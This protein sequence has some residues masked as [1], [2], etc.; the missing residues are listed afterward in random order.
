MKHAISLVAPAKHGQFTKRRLNHLLE[1]IIGSHSSTRNRIAVAGMLAGSTL[2]SADLHAAILSFDTTSIAVDEPN[3]GSQ[4]VA[5]TLRATFTDN[6]SGW[7]NLTPCTIS[8]TIGIR[9]QGSEIPPATQDQDFT[10]ITTSFSMTTEPYTVGEGQVQIDDVSQEILFEVLDDGDEN[11]SLETI[12]F[13]ITSY[14][15]SCG[16][17]ISRSISLGTTKGAIAI[18]DPFDVKPPPNPETPPSRPSAIPV[19]QKNLTAQLNSLRNLTLHSSATRDRGIAK[20]IDRARKSR[21][22]SSTNLTVKAH[23]QS[24]PNFGAG[25]GDALDNFGRW[26]LFV[27]GSVDLGHQQKGTANSSEFDSSLLIVGAD[28]QVNDHLILGSALS[29]T[30]VNSGSAQTAKTDF[31]RASFSLFASVYVAEVYYLDAIATVGASNYDLQRKID[32]G[33][34]SQDSASATTDGGETT[35]S[36]GAGYNFH[37]R[38]LNLRIFSF[39]NYIDSNIDSYREVVLGSSS[40]ASVNGFDLQS[41]TADLGFELSWNINSA[42]GVFTPALSLAQEHQFADDAV[43]INGQ[44]IGGD[45]EGGFYFH[46][47]QQD[48]DYLSTQI[49]ISGVFRNGFAAYLTYNTHLRREDFSSSQ[50]SL[51]ARWQF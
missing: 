51:G 36:I 20:E 39:V 13:E 15:A 10:H 23:G 8:G 19:R 33:E 9:N 1:L 38:N 49:G 34:S 47:P 25:A 42:F 17:E 41:L 40:A 5:V 50:Y 2:L 45:D 16:A 37:Q 14:G 31:D 7:Q 11:E 26:G 44:F 6:A 27:S 4:T 12:D 35:V 48:D 30:I 28:Y 29:H 24:L 43:D 3:A 18:S 46:G 32:T 22:F 21:G